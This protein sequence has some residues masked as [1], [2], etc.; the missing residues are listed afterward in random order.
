MKVP[1]NSKPVRILL[2]ALA[3]CGAILPATGRAQSAPRTYTLFEGANIS[4]HV[5]NSLFPVRDVDGPDWVV[6]EN[7][8]DT[9]IS[10]KKG[11][12]NLKISPMLKL[13]EDTVT[14]SDFKRT[15][16]YTFANDPE[17]KL[18]R[19]IS[20]A[21]DVN[22][23]YQAAAS[24]ASAVNPLLFGPPAT[25]G[26]HT[27]TNGALAQDTS[28]DAAASA[29][30]GAD[31]SDVSTMVQDSTGGHDA[32]E[33]EF[34]I[35]SPQPLE[36]PYIITM[37]LFHPKA[38][39]PGVVQSLVYA[40]A[41]A[42]IGDKP[43]KIHFT[44]EGFPIDYTVTNFQI[45]L[46]NHGIE[47][48]TNVSEKHR[49]MSPD[50]AFEYVKGLYLETHKSDTMH[51]VPV[52]AELPT[53]LRAKIAMGKYSE[54]IYVKVSKD[55]LANEAFADPACS[56]K[57]DDPYLDA[58]VSTVRFKPALEQGKPVEGVAS[59]NLSRLRI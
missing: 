43:S 37:T 32:M 29:A 28:G 18:T 56:K 6:D 40:K 7:G 22:A 53:D 1:M 12:V 13:T 41:L 31:A 49:E 26:T 8:K 27:G 39:E 42:P 16:A 44:E 38:S 45:H 2:P 46:Y 58:V 3:L 4:V 34:E 54:T 21:A 9:V 50:Q 5:D 14:I 57:I 19:G 24:Q 35:S 36:D 30:A 11:P 55:G 48:G 33:V 10:G 17:V 20:Q 47:V 23:G 15:A 52:M 51:A 59:L 25:S